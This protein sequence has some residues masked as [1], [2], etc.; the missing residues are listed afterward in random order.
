MRP[1]PDVVLEPGRFAALR[2][3]LARYSGVYLDETRQ[4]ALT[5]S[6]ARR[7]L[8]T[9]QNQADYIEHILQSDARAEL[10]KLAE[11][12]LNHETLFFRNQP[13]MQALRSV[14]WHEM[15][16]RKAPGAPIR[17]WSAGCATGEEPYS[18][19]I[20]ALE[21][22][23]EPLPRPVIIHATDLSTAA[24]NRAR[25]GVYNGRTLNNVDAARR[26]RFFEQ[27]SAGYAVAPNVRELVQFA[28][29]NLLDPFPAWAQGVDAIFCQNVTI[30]FQV[31]TCRALMGRFYAA[32][33]DDGLLFLGF[34]ETLWNIFDRFVSRDIH[35]AFVYAKP[36]SE[37]HAPHQR[38]TL[39]V[40]PLAATSSPRNTPNLRR[41]VEPRSRPTGLRRPRVIRSPQSTEGSIERGRALI[42]AG[43]Y[44]EA[45]QT[46]YAL[47]LNQPA[48]PMALALAA[49]A[50]ANR[51]DTDL[52][53]AEARRSLELD[54]LTIDAYILLGML[55]AQASSL[56]SP[57]CPY[58]SKAVRQL[59]RARYLDPELPLVSYHLADVFRR[60][61]RSD[62]ALRE[63]RNTLRKLAEYPADELLDGVA[64]SWIRETCQRHIDHLDPAGKHKMGG[65]V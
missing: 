21:T 35:G 11:L 25:A 12:I 27:C 7:L 36:A 40:D 52:A 46:L 50:H 32:L 19:A 23:G 43:R 47:P 54:N 33:P 8:E 9:G 29:S 1:Q 26:D 37:P 17:I 28:Q 13:H 58:L 61:G 41:P 63:Y 30:Y 64:V 39:P 5:G 44:D 56:P 49:R 3:L 42:D 45:L 51:G 53:I 62:A 15:S 4:R 55:Y 34:S 6:I 10:Q 59:E 24:L 16:R 65:R 38:A 22:L 60:Q 31:D 57:T 18:L 14:L 20:S 2:D 48:A